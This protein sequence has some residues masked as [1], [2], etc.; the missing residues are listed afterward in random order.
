MIKNLKK[1]MTTWTPSRVL[2][3][4]FIA[5]I[6]LGTILLKLP[7]AVHEGLHITWI[8]AF[9][10]ATSAIC[11]TGLTV[12]DTGATFTVFGETIIM[13]LVQLGGIG[14][15]TV[16]MLVYL[17]LGKRISLRERLILQETM[18]AGSMEGI[19]RII[20]RTIIFVF[21]I[22]TVAALIL[23]LH[24]MPEMS[25]GQALYYGVF[26]SVSLFN[27]GGFDLFGNSF[28]NY[29]DDLLFNLIA[30]ILVISGSLGFIVLAELYDYPRLRKLSLHSKVVLS[31]TGI[32]IAVGAIFILL[33]E[34]S[35]PHTLKN[36]SL[37]GK[38]YSTMFQ[39]IS[40]RS[41]GT[42]TVDITNMNQ[43][44]QFFM[45]ILMFIG[46][47]PGS[48]GGGIKTTT[49][50]ILIAAVWA[51]MRGREDVV[52]FRNRLSKDLILKTLTIIFLAIFM[53][54]SVAMLLAITEDQPFLAILFDTTSAVATVGLSMGVTEQMSEF[55]KIV[56]CFAMFIGRLGPMTLAYA[57]GTRR[58][59]SLY[60]YPEGKIMIG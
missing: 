6:G 51:M 31:V 53:V 14:F 60:R 19:V 36:M 47:S 11:V 33:F 20:R 28:Q 44:T 22:Q 32:L 39:S 37:E 25:A 48:A 34:W 10:T 54:L 16:A 49:F 7:I 58:E 13:L 9:F 45:I 52:L 57:L 29:A 40:T 55:G 30:F 26:H 4:G 23:A 8:D 18:N 56:L 42:T 35:N 41:S 3:F 21:V 43:V 1:Q 17:M 24:W 12:V 38:L 5:L 27:N 46:G 2:L 50:A 59:Q 15:M